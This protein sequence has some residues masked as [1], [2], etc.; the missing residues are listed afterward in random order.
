MAVALAFGPEKVDELV[1][2]A[3]SHAAN[4]QIEYANEK[5]N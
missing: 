4:I 5:M 2:T 1:Q 3:K